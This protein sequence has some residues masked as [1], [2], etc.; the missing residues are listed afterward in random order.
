V[1]GVWP[2][3]TVVRKIVSDGT[4]VTTAAAVEPSG[5]SSSEEAH[6]I[7]GRGEQEAAAMML[8]R[9][10]YEAFAPVWPDMKEFPV[11]S[12]RKCI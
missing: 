2:A 12:A 10:S 7:K 8:G 11:R 9:A 4:P 1:D 5:T 3:A 6:E